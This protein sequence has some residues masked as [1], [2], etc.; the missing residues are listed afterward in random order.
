MT[1][2]TMSNTPTIKRGGVYRWTGKA[3]LM[4]YVSQDGV[5]HQFA[6]LNGYGKICCELLDDDLQ[7]LEEVSH[8]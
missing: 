3:K 1:D 7:M 4:V 8:E 6:S 2:T 5:W